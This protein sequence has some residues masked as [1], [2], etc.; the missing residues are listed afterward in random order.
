M[1]QDEIAIAPVQRMVRLHFDDTILSVSPHRRKVWFTVAA[2]LKCVADLQYEITSKLL[3]VSK[4][5]DGVV[6]YLA[7]Q[8][9][10]LLPDQVGDDDIK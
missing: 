4:G 2:H 8:G 10:T 6:L 5:A 9:F 3:S 1:M 7:F